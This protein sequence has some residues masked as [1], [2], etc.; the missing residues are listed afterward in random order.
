MRQTDVAS[1]AMFS[2]AEMIKVSELTLFRLC[3]S[4]RLL[5]GRAGLRCTDQQWEFIW[6]GIIHLLLFSVVVV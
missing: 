3:F 1:L 4:F 2:E 6:T 5:F